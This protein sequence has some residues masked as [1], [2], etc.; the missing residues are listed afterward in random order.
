MYLEAVRASASR[1][2]CIEPDV[3]M[4]ITTSFGP[5]AAAA[6]HGR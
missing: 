3:S 5:D 1:P 4:T 6:Y 2:P